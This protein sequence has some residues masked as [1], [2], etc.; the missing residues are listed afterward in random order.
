LAGGYKRG[1]E[2]RLRA[3]AR[4]PKPFL[5]IQTPIFVGIGGRI[6]GVVLVFASWPFFPQFFRRRPFEAADP[7]ILAADAH[8]G[9][10]RES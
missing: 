10:G 6:V 1:S 4:Q 7:A 9:D 2:L 3:E 5:G 8:Y